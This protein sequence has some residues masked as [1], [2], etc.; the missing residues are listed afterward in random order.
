MLLMQLE[1]PAVIIT[2][3]KEKETVRLLLRE[4]PPGF[5]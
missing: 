1:K 3:I 5:F 2:G 4:Q